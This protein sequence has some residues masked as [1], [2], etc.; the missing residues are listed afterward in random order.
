[1]RLRVDAG[2][3][4]EQKTG[5]WHPVLDESTKRSTNSARGIPAPLNIRI[6]PASLAI[7]LS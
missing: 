5:L 2:E 3:E 6:L 7:T 1:M 4:K